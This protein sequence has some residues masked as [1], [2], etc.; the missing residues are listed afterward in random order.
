[1]KL[2]RSTVLVAV[3]ALLIGY[4]LS[5]NAGPAPTPDRP[6]LRW[7]VRAAKQLLWV[8]AFAEPPPAHPEP[9][10]RLVQSPAIGADGYPIIDHGRGL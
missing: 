8:A 6:V 5:G 4:W 10:Q 1:M 2:D 3:V 9:E 7:I